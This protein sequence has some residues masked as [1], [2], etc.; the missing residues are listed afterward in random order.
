MT[1]FKEWVVP[2][3][4]KQP[5]GHILANLEEVQKFVGRAAQNGLV[6][7]NSSFIVYNIIDS[8][9]NWKKGLLKKQEDSTWK[10][11]Y[12]SSCEQFVQWLINK[13]IIPV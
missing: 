5:E 12:E 2:T 4:Y 8:D 1:D 6:L 10:G 7:Y 9:G 3:I 13:K 11:F